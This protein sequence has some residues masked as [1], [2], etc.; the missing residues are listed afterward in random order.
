MGTSAGPSLAPAGLG[1]AGFGPP[2]PAA[3]YLW[4]WELPR[5]HPWPPRAWAPPASDRRILRRS[6]SGCGNFRGAIPGPRG[7]GRRRLRTA[8][9]CGGVPLGVGTSAGPSLA[10]AGLGAAGFGPPH[11]AAEYLW[12]WKL[13]G[14]IPGPRSRVSEFPAPTASVRRRGPTCSRCRL[15]RSPGGSS[16]RT[17][18]R[19]Q[20]PPPR[21]SPCGSV[22]STRRSPW[23]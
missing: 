21:S 2:H 4:V 22:S 18:R 16:R 7:L 15:R 9:S 3:E 13:R 23:N 17:R 5:G 1:A 6:T 8:A 12:V 19:P 10:P 14:A 11:P 20:T